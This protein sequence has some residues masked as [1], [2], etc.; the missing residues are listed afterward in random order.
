MNCRSVLIGLACLS[1]P[2][3]LIAD[4]PAPPIP[5]PPE[6][7]V[8]P[9]RDLGP[10]PDDIKP[11]PAPATESDELL[12]ASEA[13]ANRKY[14]E[15]AALFAEASRQNRP[16]TQ[17]HRD[18]WAYCRLHAIAVR[19]NNSDHASVPAELARDVE[20]ALK[21]ASERL[22]PFGTQ[23]LDEIRRRSTDKRT[24]DVA[25]WQAVE[26][27]SFRVLYR[28]DRGRATEAAQTAEAARSA[29]YERWVGPAG[30]AWSPRCDIYL[31]PT[32]THYAK[33]T[34]KPAEQTG[35][36]TVEIRGGRPVTRRIDL[37][38][39]DAAML[40][41]TLPFE[42]TQ[43]LLA[44]LFADEPLPRWAAVGMAALS[45]SPEAVARYRRAVPAL[46]KDKKL[47][48]VG[49]FLERKDFPEAQSVTAFYAE[50][51]SLVSY[52]VELRGPKAFAAFLREAPRRGYAKALA[53]HY[54]FKDAA[55][56]Q[57]RWVR[58]AMGGE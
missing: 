46:L 2:I 51:V 22:Q 18:E 9:M 26:A 44:E 8:A 7:P 28:V 31:H 23:L 14:S 34:G 33:A 38:A 24:T 6:D 53:S 41:T 17:S 1:F 42:V 10:S 25:G 48:A 15:A 56:L 37:R 13:F 49:P 45:E 57:D 58:H 20:D 3:P 47:F 12:R 11:P 5:P 19:L 36:S 54:G 55:D 40:E 21:I 43:V 32:G 30:S 50:S 4:P 35:H 16:L 52:L 29:M 39:D 27:A